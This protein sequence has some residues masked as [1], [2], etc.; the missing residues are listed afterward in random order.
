MALETKTSSIVPL[1]GSNYPTWKIQCR[2]T[3][4]KDSLW[5]L[6]DGT[7]MVSP[8]TEAERHA[9]YVTKKNRALEI[10]VLSIETCLL[11]LLGDPQ[12]PVVVW[13]KLAA[14]FQKKTWANKLALQRKLYSLRLKQS[15]SVQQHIKE[16]TEVFEELSIVGDPIEE[17]DPVVHLLASLPPSFDAL[18]TAPEASEDV[19]KMEMVTERLLR[20][21]MKQKEKGACGGTAHDVKL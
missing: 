9:K 19:P 4:I 18:V 1:N 16:M 2:M 13:N 12:D 20:E 11:Y 7:E 3:L 6:I 10:V 8:R 15:Q 21:E 17:E 5:S 14:Q